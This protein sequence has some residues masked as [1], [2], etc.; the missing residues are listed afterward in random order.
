MQQLVLASSQESD[1]PGQTL[2]SR[3]MQ[4]CKVEESSEHLPNVLNIEYH[5]HQAQ[6]L[7]SAGIDGDTKKHS[8]PEGHCPQRH[9]LHSTRHE[10]LLDQLLL[11]GGPKCSSLWTLAV[12]GSEFTMEVDITCSDADCCRDLEYSIISR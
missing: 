10:D 6:P 1:R 11:Y 9:D 12:G 3:K 8:G 5:E 7:P 4:R 2:L